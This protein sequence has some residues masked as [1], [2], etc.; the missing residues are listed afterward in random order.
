MATGW[1]AP[2]GAVAKRQNVPPVA[3]NASGVGTG[4]LVN[5]NSAAMWV[6][7]SLSLITTPTSSA[8]CVMTPPTGIINTSYFAGTGDQFDGPHFLYHGDSI[9]FAWSSGPANG[10]G[11]CTYEFYELPL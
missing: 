11:L 4:Q 10:Q 5:G 8:V 1:V 7:V 3:L 6:I 2:V 9:N